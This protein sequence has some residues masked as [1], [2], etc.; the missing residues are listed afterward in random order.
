MLKRLAKYSIYS[1][2]L[3]PKATNLCVWAFER[4]YAGEKT[5]RKNKEKKQEENGARSQRTERHT[6]FS[7]RVSY[8]S[9]LLVLSPFGK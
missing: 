3:D 1:I 4:E 5:H 9:F 2:H 6:T 7:V 8:K